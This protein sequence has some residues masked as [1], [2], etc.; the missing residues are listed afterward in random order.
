MVAYSDADEDIYPNPD[1]TIDYAVDMFKNKG[2]L[3]I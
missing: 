1:I 3:H 2:D